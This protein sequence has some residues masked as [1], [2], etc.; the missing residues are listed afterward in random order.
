MSIE[1]VVDANI[2]ISALIG[3]ATREILFETKFDFI[4]TQFTISEVEKYFSEIA[5]KA[6]VSENYVKE[7]FDLLPLEVKNKEFYQGNLDKA[8][9]LIKDIDKKDV[10]ILALALETGNYLWTDDRDFDKI[11]FEK[12]IKTKDFF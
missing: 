10:D 6:E 8:E 5:R 7:T 3:G 11:K 1:I 9:E 4:T 12:V 2:I